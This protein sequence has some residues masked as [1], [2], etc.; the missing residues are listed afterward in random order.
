[1]DVFLDAK[2]AAGMSEH[3]CCI[4]TYACVPTG[5][6]DVLWFTFIVVPLHLQSPVQ[7]NPVNH[8]LFQ[9][10]SALGYLVNKTQI[11]KCG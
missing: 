4:Q 2:E 11:F 3:R 1:M 7:N 8:Q 10:Y 9:H 5:V 6:E